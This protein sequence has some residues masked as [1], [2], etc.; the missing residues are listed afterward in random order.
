MKDVFNPRLIALCGF[1]EVG[2]STVQKALASLYGVKICDDGRLLRDAAMALYGF[3]EDMVTTQAGKA[4]LVDICGRKDTVR[5]FMGELGCAIENMHGTSF[6]PHQ[7]LERLKLQYGPGLEAAPRMSFG[8]V[9]R[10]QPWFFREQG[11]LVIEVVGANAGR[12]VGPYDRYDAS[13]AHLTI[14]N[15]RNG[16]DE[17]ESILREALDKYLLDEPA[18]ENRDLCDIGAA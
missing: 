5:T 15:P 3:T 11:A 4:T 17:L 1:P 12:N 14:H 7:T 2:K 8:S 9:R 18:R 16:T 10:D 6:F 13:A